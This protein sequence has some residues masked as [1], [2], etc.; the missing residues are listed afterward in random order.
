[1]LGENKAGPLERRRSWGLSPFYD[2]RFGFG[3]NST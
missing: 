1:M 2:E 3:F